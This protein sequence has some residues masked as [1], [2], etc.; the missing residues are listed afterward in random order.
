VSA[1]RAFI[2]GVIAIVFAI[3]VALVA[4]TGGFHGVL[5]EVA[6]F[7]GAVGATAFGLLAFINAWR[8]QR[9]ETPPD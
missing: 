3:A 6:G 9:T 8:L 7:A 2:V 5:G 1:T 4:Y